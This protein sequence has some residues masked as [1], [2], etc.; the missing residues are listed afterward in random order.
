[1]ATLTAAGAPAHAAGSLT[2]F[3]S[4]SGKVELSLS[5]RE[6]ILLQWGLQT[7]ESEAMR[8]ELEVKTI[9]KD[10]LEQSLQKMKEGFAATNTTDPDELE[11][12]EA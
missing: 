5:T 9:L 11:I 12:Q 1:M 10:G 3:G 8:E 2:T 4:A 6:K 7:L